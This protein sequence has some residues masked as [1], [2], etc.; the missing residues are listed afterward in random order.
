M[1]TPMPG[2]RLLRRGAHQAA[3]VVRAAPVADDHVL[4]GAQ[5]QHPDVLRVLPADDRPA[6]VQIRPGHEKPCHI[7]PSVNC[8]AHYLTERA[9]LQAPRTRRRG[10]A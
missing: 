8:F 7:A 2:L 6:S 9:R 4:A 10:R 3:A 5:A 1:P